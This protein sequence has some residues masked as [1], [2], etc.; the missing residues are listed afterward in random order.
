MKYRVCQRSPSH[1]DEDSPTLRQ[2]Q[3]RLAVSD[4]IRS[5]VL[6]VRCRGVAL[7]LAADTSLTNFFAFMLGSTSALPAVEY[8]CLY[9]GTA[10]MF[11]FMLQVTSISRHDSP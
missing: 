9:A 6:P 3:S 7:V 11:D 8:F 2:S 5:P 10:I 4:P 1:H